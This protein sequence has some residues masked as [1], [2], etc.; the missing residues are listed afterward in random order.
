MDEGRG[1][2]NAGEALVDYW[3]VGHTKVEWGAW[4]F[5]SAGYS[6]RRQNVHG[7][8]S[9][10]FRI[11]KRLAKYSMLDVGCWLLPCRRADIV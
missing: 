4:P 8:W 6:L 10:A 7:L 1:L 9:T 5:V 2:E 3:M 11:L